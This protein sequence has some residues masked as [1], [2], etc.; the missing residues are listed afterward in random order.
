MGTP[1]RRPVVIDLVCQLTA[2]LPFEA[3]QAR[4]MQQ[5]LTALLLLAPMT[6]VLGVQVVSFRMAFFSD[7][8][9]HSAFAGVAL[10][11]IA[12]V[13]PHLTMPVF[14]VLVGLA[15]M[16]LCRHS[17]LSADTVTGVVFSAVVAFGLAVVSRHNTVARDLQQ[18]L[19]GDILTVGEADIQWLMVLLGIFVVFQFFACNRLLYI[20][21]HP[22]VARA[23]GVPVARCQYLF[24]VLLALVVMFSVWGVGVLLVT[25]LLIVPAAAARNFA[26]TA[27]GM[28]WWALLVSLSSSAT[29]L[30]LSAQPWL[31]TATG[32]TIIL[33]ACAW[34]AVSAVWAALRGWRRD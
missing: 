33:T 6:A 5:A 25:A 10:G 4:F 7:A 8:I 14:G 32:A 22:V 1:A 9:S 29:G 12:G 27:G 30:I 34:F 11:L 26:S 13:H 18:F 3:M 28:Y 17:S 19:Y 23:H 21:L 15:V 24:A 20:G 2:L 31:G 16:L